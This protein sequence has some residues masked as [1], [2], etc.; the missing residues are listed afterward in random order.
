LSGVTFLQCDVVLLPRVFQTLTE[1]QS[2]SRY[3]YYRDLLVQFETPHSQGIIH[4]LCNCRF[5]T[6]KSKTER[7]MILDSPWI[8]IKQPSRVICS[9]HYSF[10]KLS[11]KNL[12]GFME[13]C[14]KSTTHG[15]AITFSTHSGTQRPSTLK[16]TAEN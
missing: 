11:R 15:S 13:L 3:I 16:I 14:N 8:Q 2:K 4:V 12:L 1:L 9:L 5:S 10:C 6:H 7:G